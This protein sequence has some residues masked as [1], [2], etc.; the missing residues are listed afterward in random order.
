MN[1][2]GIK[3]GITEI[4]SQYIDDL[5]K[6]DSKPFEVTAVSLGTISSIGNSTYCGSEITPL[7][8]I[9]AVVN[10]ETVELQ[11]G[12]DYT[13]TYSN[14]INASTQQQK[15]TVTATGIGNFT[16]SLTTTWTILPKVASLQWGDT[17]WT[18]DGNEHHTT[19]VV[20]NLEAGD[21]CNVILSGNS[22]TNIGSVTVTATGLSNP[23][24][25]LPDDVTVTLVIEAGLFVRLS[26]TWT[27]VRK[28]FKKVSGSWVEQN[29]MSAFNT[30]QAY[31]K[32]N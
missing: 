16:G 30:A 10:G 27:P 3:V 6:S 1:I 28:V 13:L 7:P 9:T 32:M 22:I 21:T 26:G 11:N 23:N 18:F 24:Y 31:I 15:A 12:I 8:K 5:T 4:T 19:C 29:P 2:K 25:I 14:N 20:S 17:L